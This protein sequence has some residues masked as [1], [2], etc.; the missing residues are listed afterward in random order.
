LQRADHIW[1]ALFFVTYP[2]EVRWIGSYFPLH[3]NL[4]QVQILGLRINFTGT[5][6]EK[7][8]ILNTSELSSEVFDFSRI[9][10]F[11][12]ASDLHYAD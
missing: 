8:D 6:E 2:Y 9:V 1:S 7:V 5:V 12:I 4:D 3:P 10:G 11:R